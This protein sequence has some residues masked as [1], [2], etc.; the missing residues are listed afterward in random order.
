MGR[1][2]Y[3]E[4]DSKYEARLRNL[5]DE[6]GGGINIH[7]VDRDTLI[8]EDLIA[9]VS[10]G[11]IPLTIVDSDIARIN[12]TYYNDLDITMQVSFPQRSQWLRRT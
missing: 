8:A 12:K 1:D 9:M 5:N 10:N 6:I 11:E 2:V 3:V 7:T 4:R